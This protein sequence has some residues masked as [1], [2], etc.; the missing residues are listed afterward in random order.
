MPDFLK[1]YRCM[2]WN[3][4]I[5]LFLIV[6]KLFIFIFLVSFTWLGGTIHKDN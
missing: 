5:N 4:G 6:P 1:T 3:L 2:F